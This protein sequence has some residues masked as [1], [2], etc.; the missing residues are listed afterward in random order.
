MPLSKEQRDTGL[1]C[2]YYCRQDQ[3]SVSLGCGLGAGMAK[4]MGCKVSLGALY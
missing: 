3:T 2:C 1:H 4:G